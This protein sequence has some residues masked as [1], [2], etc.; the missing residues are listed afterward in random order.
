MAPVPQV[1]GKPY[2]KFQSCD[3]QMSLCKSASRKVRMFC[4]YTIL[5]THF[6]CAFPCVSHKYGGR[7]GE[8][9]AV[10]SGQEGNKWTYLEERTLCKGAFHI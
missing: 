7:G 2:P 8:T 6:P 9:D 10:C 4:V 3:S 5:L 1:Q